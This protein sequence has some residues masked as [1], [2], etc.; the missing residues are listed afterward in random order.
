M[1]R[2]KILSK[3]EGGLKFECSWLTACLFLMLLFTALNGY[4]DAIDYEYG[5]TDFWQCTF[6]GEPVDVHG[7]MVK[8]ALSLTSTEPS[9]LWDWPPHYQ[10]FY[11]HNFYGH[12]EDIAKGRLTVYDHPP[13]TLLIFTGF[14]KGMLATGPVFMVTMIYIAAGMA[15]GLVVWYFVTNWWERVFAF[16]VLGLGYPFLFAL[17]RA[18]L[19][20]LIV[21]FTLAFFIYLTC[22]RRHWIIPSICLGIACSIRPNAVL[23]APLLLCFGWR[24]SIMAGSIFLATTVILTAISYAALIQIYP[25]YS[26]QVFLEALDSYRRY[27][28]IG[29]LGDGNNNS[30]YGAIKLLCGIFLIPPTPDFLQNMNWVIVIACAGLIAFVSYRHWRGRL[31]AYYF[32]FALTC[33]YVLASTIFATYHLLVLYAFILMAGRKAET[34]GSFPPWVLFMAVLV[35]IPKNYFY[36]FPGLSFEVILNPL[37]LLVALVWILFMKFPAEM[38]PPVV[39]IAVEENAETKANR[40][41]RRHH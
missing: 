4:V 15:L 22:N 5:A 2:M 1:G 27:Y 3:T 7:D 21:G 28:V 12:L 18:N 38:E 30:L 37:I 8:V 19:G 26:W 36:P 16:V 34:A 20:S 31:P 17:M 33:L 32:A 24:Q 10:N 40:K 25:G 35:L 9:N 41:R 29:P 11:E 39:S 6:L 14:L 13:V 23:L